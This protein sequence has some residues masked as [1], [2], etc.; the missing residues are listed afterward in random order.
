MTAD[1]EPQKQVGIAAFGVSKAD[2][3]SRYERI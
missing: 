3:P 1:G 2:D